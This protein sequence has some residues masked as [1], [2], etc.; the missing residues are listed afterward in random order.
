MIMVKVMGSAACASAVPRVDSA[1]ARG[2]RRLPYRGGES[3][4]CTMAAH[5]SAGRRHAGDGV[6]LRT[7]AGRLM[8][9]GRG[10]RTTART[11][12]DAQVGRRAG[13]SSVRSTSRCAGLDTPAPA[14]RAA[15][16]CRC[17]RVA[18]R[19]GV[20][21]RTSGRP[22]QRVTPRSAMVRGDGG[23]DDWSSSGYGARS[24]GV[25]CSAKGARC[26]HRLARGVRRGRPPAR[27]S[28]AGLGAVKVLLPGRWEA[29]RL[30]QEPVESEAPSPTAERLGCEEERS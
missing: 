5:Y 11:G 15:R 30:Q 12:R 18:A 16:R 4:A 8:T 14:R 2:C 6:R 17:A 20:R 21:P 23:D 25:D 10:R 1:R 7:H 19:V 3:S 27:A 13:G 9:R 28:L 22:H 29:T 26:A 24:A